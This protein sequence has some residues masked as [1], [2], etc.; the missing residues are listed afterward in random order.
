MD[1]LGESCPTQA[2]LPPG[3]LA[4]DKIIRD[5]YNPGC[6]AE[7]KL[8]VDSIGCQTGQLGSSYG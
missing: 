6:Q 1:F 3:G 8:S 5:R 7:A 2:V 4:A